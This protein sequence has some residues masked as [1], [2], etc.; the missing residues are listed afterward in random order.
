MTHL[1]CN[2]ILIIIIIIIINSN[3]SVLAADIGNAYPHAKTSEKLY[4]ILGEEYGSLGGKI[5]VFDKGLY[6]LRSSGARFHEHLSDILR[7]MDFFPS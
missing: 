3:L 1:A 4:T 6:G 7:K 2:K 5:L